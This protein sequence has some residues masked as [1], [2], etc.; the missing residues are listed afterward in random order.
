M[1]VFMDLEFTGLHQG[2]TI[3]SLGAI[4]D[5]EKVPELIHDDR[6]EGDG[7]F[8]AELNDYDKNQ[9]DPWI[10]KNVINNLY[11]HTPVPSLYYRNIDRKTLRDNLEK[12]LNQLY[13]ID[14]TPIEMWLDCYAYD[15]VLFCELW[16]GALN[17]P[18][19]VHYIPRDLSTYLEVMGEDP[20]V[21]REQFAN[22]PKNSCSQS[23]KH[24]AL[25]DAE[26]IRY[27]YLELQRRD[28]C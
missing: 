14:G 2:S 5:S 20:D 24:N 10:K 7:T 12:W 25:W 27:C 15:W 28:R 18:N 6:V 4:A 21:N 11:S 23:V 19:C 3:I 26:V 17:V 16:G 22:V 8:Y 9:V 13:S 1:K